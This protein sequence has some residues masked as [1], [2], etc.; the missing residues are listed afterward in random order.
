MKHANSILHLRRQQLAQSTRA[1]RARGSRAQRCEE[2]L[3]PIAN[4]ICAD[5]PGITCDSAFCFLMY[6]GEAYKPS[7]TG[8][9]I[10]DIAP[11]N[12]AFAWHRTEHDPQ[13][14]A[15][16][17]DPQYV[18]ILVFPHQ[19]AETHR[20][21]HRPQQA[22]AAGTGS[23]LLFV[24]LDGTWREAKKMFRSPYLQHLPVL[25]I[26]PQQLSRYLLRD[27]P[28][29]HQLCTVEVGIEVLRLAGEETAA[30]A[31][32]VYFDRF[33]ECYAVLKPH[34]L[35]KARAV[36]SPVPTPGPPNPSR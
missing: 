3:L 12:Y 28:M 27:A 1:F 23:K 8:R 26:Q 5:R 17:A 4:C 36:P 13:L 30:S 20:Q 35:A 32:A 9:L 33:S 29:S 19:Y 18:P 10:A 21:I 34:L 11:D 7:N 14:L 24:M 2:C 25:G 22:I 6:H 31:L 16:L 15:L